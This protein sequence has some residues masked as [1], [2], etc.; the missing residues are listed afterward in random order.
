LIQAESTLSGLLGQTHTACIEVRD[1]IHALI[2]DAEIY[3]SIFNPEG[4]EIYGSILSTKTLVV[5]ESGY[6]EIEW[7]PTKTGNYTIII[8]YEGTEF[9]ESSSLTLIIKI[10]Y[11]TNLDVSAPES[12]NYPDSGRLMV[13]LSGGLGKVSGAEIRIRIVIGD[14]S[15]EEILLVTD[16]R[17]LVQADIDP[18]YAGNMTIEVEYLGS[19]IYAECKMILSVLIYPAVDLEISS[20]PAYYTGVNGSIT[21]AV[22]IQGLVDSWRGTLNLLIYSNLNEL[23]RN[24]STTTKAVDTIILRFVTY[25]LGIYSI[26]VKISGVPLLGTANATGSFEITDTPLSIPMD[27]GS[28]TVMS[29]GIILG[30]IGFALRKKLTGA[31]DNVSVEWDI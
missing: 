9:I 3:V 6:A 28:T 5:T 19:D 12:I 16:V 22:D 26:L 29:S 15:E 11:E 4:K 31:L 24:Y 18:S 25:D 17:G 13:T 7:T 21:V 30:I 20:S 23:V 1:S 27:T 8:E 2:S 14:L 10:R